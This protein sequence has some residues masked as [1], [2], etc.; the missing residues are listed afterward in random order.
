MTPIYTDSCLAFQIEGQ[1]IKG[2][3]IR[4]DKSL[5]EVLG[6]HN[7]PEA[8][9]RDLGQ[10]MTI[11]A[12]LGSMMKFDGILTLQLKSDGAV[13]SLVSDYATD[14]KGTGVVRGYCGLNEAPDGL[15][16]LGNGQMM[17]TMDQGQY[18]ERYQGIVALKNNSLKASAEEYFHTSEQLPTHLMIDC[19]RDASGKWCGAAIMI[20]HLARNTQAE[21]ARVHESDDAEDQ[22]NTASILLGSVKSE[23]LLDTTLSLQDL[24]LRL[25]HESGVRVFTNTELTTG[26]RCSDKKLRTVLASFKTEELHDIAEEGVITMT[27]EFCKTD[28]KFELKKLIN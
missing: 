14:G 11:S 17:I 20:Q 28:H 22:W 13:K 26:C 15:P 3:I 18:M 7:Y 9:S 24:L 8:V 6:K 2:R 23:E 1:D 27:C 19:A 21:A 25:F 5:N 16:T 12:L 4:L 10:A